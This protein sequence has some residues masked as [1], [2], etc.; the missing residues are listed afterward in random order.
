MTEKSVTSNTGH[1]GLGTGI[2]TS[3]S[4]TY[5]QL[6]GVL[7]SPGMTFVVISNL[8][9][10]KSA[11]QSGVSKTVETLK[12]PRRMIGHGTRGTYTGKSNVMSHEHLSG[13]LQPSPGSLVD[14]MLNVGCSS[15]QSSAPV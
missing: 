11:R 10:G 5:S 14:V 2:K 13:T 8:L 15:G 3:R 7:Q 1:G 4:K 9:G 6:S 12:S